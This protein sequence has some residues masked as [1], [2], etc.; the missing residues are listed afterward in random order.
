MEKYINNLFLR[1]LFFLTSI[2][3]FSYTCYARYD[4]YD[5]SANGVYYHITSNTTESKT[6]EVTFEYWYEGYSDDYPRNDY[7]GD[8]VIPS[9]VTYNS[10]V[11]EVTRIGSDAFTGSSITSVALPNSITTI[12]G[13][14]FSD[15]RKLTSIFLPQSVRNIDYSA[16]NGCTNLVSAYISDGVTSIGSS[17]FADCRS[18]YSITVPNTVKFIGTDAFAGTGWYNEQPDGL[19]YAG[20]VA[21]KYKGTMPAGTQITIK[22]GTLGIAGSA[23]YN[24]S[25]LT[26]VTIPNSVTSIGSDAF[27]NCSGLTK[28]IVS[29]ISAWCNISFSRFSSNP[30]NFAHHLYMNG[31]EIKNLVIPNSVTSIGEYAFYNCSGLASVTIPNSVTSIG[32]SV[33]SGCSGLTSVTIGNGVTS[34]G[35]Y[36][37]SGCSG[38]TSVTIPISVTSI[39]SDAF[40]GCYFASSAFINNSSLTSSNYWGATLCDE[41]TNDGLMIKN[42]VVV[43]CRPWVISVTIPTSVT[44]IGSSAFYNC[45]GLTSITIPNSVTSIGN[46]AFKNCSSL[47][48]ITIPSSVT[49]IGSYAFENCS[50]LISIGVEL[51]N[52]KYDSRDNCNAIIETATNTLIYGCQNTIIPGNV[53]SIGSYAFSGCSGLTFITIPNSVTSIGS[54]A[55]AY[56]SG[57]TDVWCCAKDVP[58]TNSSYTF[59][60]SPIASATLHVPNVSLVKYKQNSPWS[61][62]GTIVAIKNIEFTDANVKAICVANWDTNNDSQLDDAEASVVTDLGKSFKGNKQITSFDELQFFI[63]LTS[64]EDNAFRG[65]SSLTSI[66]IPKNV[67]HISE[68]AFNGCSGLASINIPKKVTSIGAYAFSNC[69]VLTEFWCYAEALPSTDEDIFDGTNIGTATLYVPKISLEAYKTTAPWSGFRSI[70][71]IEGYTTYNINDEMASLNIEKEESGCIVD[72]THNFNGEW[73]ALYLPFAIDYDA[74]EVDFDLAEIDGVVQNDDNN[75]GIV[76][77]TVLSIIGFKEQNTAPNTPYLIRAKHA[78][79][80]TIHFEDITVYPTKSVSL[81]S[82]STSTRYE[83]TGSYNMLDASDLTNRYTIQNGELVEGANS[84]APCRW[85]MT[86][87]A[88]RGSLNLPNKIRIMPVEEVITGVETLSDSPL[89][90]ENIIHNLAGQ[91]LSKPAKGINIV[92]GKK[93]LV[94]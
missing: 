64:V 3:L 79:E 22:D 39:G 16:F 13:E 10:D 63:G 45:S 92:G 80:Q 71:P 93:V 56:C 14:A 48:S 86:A 52:T 29:D 15:C 91:R 49:S 61:S 69:S 51:G 55:F 74:I 30:L 8:I 67:T 82:S 32:S 94:K 87:T 41:E 33:F 20:K 60:T 75:D 2:Y 77:F 9:S 54:Y 70:V 31:Q 53:T 17:A 72:Y 36:S 42:N 27:Y 4:A 1:C 84:L 78:G 50:G 43:K 89:K 12:G 66:I 81:E 85:Y 11:Y 58:S 24:C 35:N 76:D 68:D 46:G 83:F 37:F 44:S 73:E 28:V 6:V 21:Y 90:G 25:G 57:L 19:V 40:S 5:F 23:F 88:K 38:L 26:S 47:T 18:L 62:F 59:S 7:S 34:I 65:C